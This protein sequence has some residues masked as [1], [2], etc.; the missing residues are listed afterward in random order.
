MSKIPFL[1]LQ[2]QYSM[3]RWELRSAMDRVCDAQ[4]FILG[5]EVAALEQNIAAFCGTKFAIGVSSGTDAL[6]AALMAVGVGPGDEVITT[7]FSFFATAGV[8][9]RLQARPVFVDIEAGSFN[10]DTNQLADTV[11]GR[12]KAILPVHL[13]GRCAETDA[14]VEIAQARRIHVIED[15][16]QA[17]GARDD[18][19][20]AAG[21]I[22]SL[23][24]FSF[25]PSKNLGAFGDGGMVVTQDGAL[26]EAVRLLRVHGA[27]PK[28]H[29]RTVGGNFR[30]DELQAAVLRVKLKYLPLWT[31]ARRRNAQRYRELFAAAGLAEPVILP[32]D[33][34]GHIYNQFVIRCADRDRLQ[35]FL[36]SRGVETEVYYPIPLHLQ[37]CFADLGYRQGDFPR[38]EAA[39][40]EVLALPI[41]P[42]LTEEQQSYVVDKICEFYC[43]PSGEATASAIR[44]AP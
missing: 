22:G 30:L 7:S 36:R 42:E 44:H 12:T 35:A 31:Q 33:T 29:H 37:E 14:I 34:P 40:A 28:Y 25:F 17:I 18:R 6:L 10:L 23:G 13:F 8:I 9:A 11:S 43:G 1:D 26:A 39:A 3:I 5:P 27:K 32:N 21:A 20:Q 24:C 4:Y 15:A 19:D 16:A 38:A 2:A 41:Y